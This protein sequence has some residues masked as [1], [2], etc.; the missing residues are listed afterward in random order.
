MGAVL[1][2][3]PD[4]DQ[5]LDLGRHV[6]GVLRVPA[7]SDH[8]T[9]A[10]IATTILG[11]LGKDA[12][13]AR[14]S[15]PKKDDLVSWT[16]SWVHA[17][18]VTTVVVTDAQL[19]SQDTL[20]STMSLAREVDRVVLVR[21]DQGEEELPW[22][23]TYPV[24]AGDWTT[25]RDRVGTAE[26]VQT[27]DGSDPLRP[28]DLPTCHFLTFRAR[29]QAQLDPQHW[30]WTDH[31][32]RT[33]FAE[34]ERAPTDPVQ[35]ATHLE[36]VILRHA[37]APADVLTIVYATQAAMFGRGW[38]MRIDPDVLWRELS[39]LRPHT[40]AEDWQKV[41]WVMDPQ[42]AATLALHLLHTPETTM[43]HLTVADAQGIV[44]SGRLGSTTMPGPART[45]L[46]AQLHQVRDQPADAAFLTRRN[47]SAVRR[48]ASTHLGLRTHR[49]RTRSEGPL[50]SPLAR[51]AMELIKI[52]ESSWS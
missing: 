15:L 31:V 20:A 50:S 52:R 39:P 38:F 30:A 23:D 17:H 49:P 46:L 47:L 7:R 32:Y 8:R 27:R 14:S 19:L 37:A 3:A 24:E 42:V 25:W 43:T 26:K 11:R 18:E 35:M 36:D 44:T 33:A 41:S 51:L 1:I 34:G 45:I 4:H 2:T 21:A 6:P 12:L 28:G 48:Y 10:D 13:R 9:E 5:M 16:R 40:S 22:Q 29:A